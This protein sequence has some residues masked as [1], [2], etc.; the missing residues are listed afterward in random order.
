MMSCAGNHPSGRPCLVDD[1][2]P[3]CQ[4]SMG[5][6]PDQRERRR[7]ESNDKE[8]EFLRPWVKKALTQLRKVDQPA[9]QKLVAAYRAF[10]STTR[11]KRDRTTIQFILDLKENR[12]RDKR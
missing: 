10:S 11:P 2:C 3:A 4:R 6:H 9:A 7:V 5:V 1:P 12:R 8:L